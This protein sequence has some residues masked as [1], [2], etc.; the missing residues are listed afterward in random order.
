MK[1]NCFDE[2]QIPTTRIR[3]GL[4]ISTAIQKHPDLI[5]FLKS[6]N[7][8]RLDFENRQ[9]LLLYNTYIAKDVYGLDI[10]LEHEKA[11]IPAPVLRYNFLQTVLKPNST[12]IELGTGPSAIIAMLAAKHFNAKVL[13]TEMDLSY[14][15]MAKKNIVRNK[16]DKQI[17]IIDSKGYLL[18]NVFSD[19]FNV[20]YIIS[21]PPYYEKILSPKLLWGGKE[22]ELVSSNHGESFIFRM[23]REGWKFL[24]NQGV[25][26]FIVPKTKS[27]TFN[28]IEQY[29]KAFD[30]EHDIIGLQTGTRTRYVFRL[31][32]KCDKY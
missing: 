19:D 13:A 5:P 32:K 9:A 10:I 28:R 26:A 27:E 17:I 12:I 20:D 31:Y 11:L 6:L 3:D 1:A 8:P 25:I 14:I 15:K 2:K 18:E 22:I 21:N 30:Y 7:P 29:L 4:P 16:L 23:I 24:K